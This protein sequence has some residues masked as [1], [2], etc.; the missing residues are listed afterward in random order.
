HPQAFDSLGR[1]L[2]DRLILAEIGWR[3]RLASQPGLCVPDERPEL[4]DIAVEIENAVPDVPRFRHAA[5]GPPPLG[6]AK[7][8][9]DD[10]FSVI[11]AYLRLTPARS[12]CREPHVNVRIWYA[13]MNLDQAAL[14]ADCIYVV[15]AF[16][17]KDI[18]EGPL[19]FAARI[20]LEFES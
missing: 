3:R 9:L 14:V 18:H 11:V 6:V 7:R 13:L 19:G 5:R 16:E 2:S 4:A 17:L 15:Y 10:L 20:M 1:L 8:L 12:V